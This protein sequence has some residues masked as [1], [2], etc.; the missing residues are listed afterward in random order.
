MEELVL[1][2]REKATG[3]FMGYDWMVTSIIN[4]GVIQVNRS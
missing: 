2:L 3:K 4:N 1:R